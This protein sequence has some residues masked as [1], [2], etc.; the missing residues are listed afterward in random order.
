M[1]YLQDTPISDIPATSL[2]PQMYPPPPPGYPPITP[3][4][5][6]AQVY[7][8]QYYQGVYPYL[9]PRKSGLP[10]WA[11][12]LLAG[13]VG[14]VILG[15]I[16]VGFSLATV[17]TWREDA[18]NVSDQ[19][20][21]AAREGNADKMYELVLPSA[22]NRLTR[23]SLQT[24]VSQRRSYLSR[25]SNLTNVT[26]KISTNNGNTVINLSGKINYNDGRTGSFTSMLQMVENSWYITDYS[27][28][29]PQ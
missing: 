5:Q 26:S 27:L 29:T 15:I 9:L 14:I 6:S 19:F 11:W 25:Y 21:K 24:F 13:W 2:T 18:L 8:N 23:V 17:S 4:Y 7:Y 20:L 3:I 16:V 10:G 1:N 12:L 28:G 22:K